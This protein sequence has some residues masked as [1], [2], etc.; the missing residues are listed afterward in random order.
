MGTRIW[1]EARYGPS[2]RDT[3]QKGQRLV[4]FRGS[5]VLT[6]ALGNVVADQQASMQSDWSQCPVAAVCKPFRGTRL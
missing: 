4:G 3:T 5:G 6:L 1:Q 2:I